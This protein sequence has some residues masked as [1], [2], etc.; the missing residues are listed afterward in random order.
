MDR[1]LSISFGILCMLMLGLSILP[2]GAEGAGTGFFNVLVTTAASQVPIEGAMVWIDDEVT[3]LTQKDGRCTFRDVDFGN[4]TLT[5]FADG[6]KPASMVI[7]FQKNATEYKFALEPAE[8]MKQGIIKGRV[9]LDVY[10]PPYDAGESMIGFETVD[11]ITLPGLVDVHTTSDPLVGEYYTLVNPGDHYLWCFAYGHVPLHS[12][13]LTVGAGA[14]VYYDFHLKYIGMHNSGLAG[15]VTDATSGAPVPGATVIA[16]DG[17]TTL[18]TSTDSSGFYFFIG[19][20]AGSYTLIAASSSYE[21]GT[22]YGNVTWGHITYVDIMLKKSDKNHTILWGIVYGD[23]IPLS[24]ANVFTDVPHIVNTHLMGIAGLYAIMDFPG[25]EDHLVG[26][27]ASGYSPVSLIL[28]V[29]AGTIQRQD[30]YLQKGG[31]QKLAVLIAS[32]YEKGTGISLNNATVAVNNPGTF[33]DTKLTGPASNVVVWVGIPSWGSYSINGLVSGYIFVEFTKSPGSGILMPSDTF[34]LSSSVINHAKLY[35]NKTQNNEKT[36]IWG[37]VTNA[38]TSLPISGCPILDITGLMTPFSTT[39][40]VGFYM[41][42]VS[43]GTFTLVALPPTGYSLMNYDHATGAWGMGP[44]TGTVVNGESRH[45]DFVVKLDKES[46]VIAGQVVELG[47]GAPIAGFDVDVTGPSMT[48]LYETTPGSGYFIFSPLWGPG[49]W[50]LDGSHPSLF[51]VSVEYW[52]LMSGTHSTSTTLPINF[53]LTIPNV[54]WVEITVQKEVPTNSTRIWGYVYTAS[55]G[56]AP[57][58]SCGILDLTYNMT[59]F[60]TTNATGYYNEL[61]TP[62]NFSLMPLAVG[63]YSI[64]AYDYAT[65]VYSVAPW[66]GTVVN[67]ESRHVD[68]IMKQ[69]REAAIIAGQVTMDGTG[70]PVSGFNVGASSGSLSYNAL[71]PS[72]GFFIFPPIYLFSTWQV[73]GFHPTLYVVEVKYHLFPSGAV[74]TNPSLPVSFSLS[75]SQIMWVDI[76]VDDVQPETARIFGKVYKLFSY[77]P[78]AGA[79]VNIY[80]MPGTILTYTLT[81]DAVGYY[82]QV[83]SPGDYYVKASLSGYGASAATLTLLPGDNI[84]QPFYLMPRIPIPHPMNITMKFV[85]KTNLTPIEALKVEI[86]GVAKMVTDEN[87]LIHFSIPEAG[88]YTLHIAAAYAMVYDSANNEIGSMDGPIKLESNS[89]YTAKVS[90][91]QKI[92][93]TNTPKKSEGLNVSP[94][95]GIGLLAVALIVGGIVGYALHRPKRSDIEE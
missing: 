52:L 83:L 31:D 70:A 84:Y 53:G 67:G 94:L 73:S 71:T 50:T 76:I 36:N 65:G 48:T 19:P 42:Y 87:G 49:T 29:P 33:T 10:D 51:V 62:G 57:I 28:N 8:P 15:N 20:N 4:H 37:Y 39:D 3:W 12:S 69:D 81:A 32:V 88:E 18:V 41:E 27:M 22:A 64:S 6:Y 14:V 54:M 45:V 80:Q 34:T 66:S 68:F 47:T 78:A 91:Y 11:S 56:G 77:A 89:T 24:T 1:K 26:A 46:M 5:V 40:P 74:S 44:W 13:V 86:V 55:M 79:A 9:F 63:G 92:E 59:L 61:V 38:A 30:F 58:P 2:M 43:P 75:S 95:A 93:I 7:D 35:M 85:E 23:G 82:E 17:T 16:T 25:D 60:S 21:P 90:F 72:N